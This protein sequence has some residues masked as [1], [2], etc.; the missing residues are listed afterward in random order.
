[1][2]FLCLLFF[3][4]SF[5][6]TNLF[7]YMKGRYVAVGF[8]EVHE[9]LFLYFFSSSELQWVS[10]R[11]TWCPQ[12]LWVDLVSNEVQPSQP[13][14]LSSESTVSSLKRYSHSSVLLGDMR[15]WEPCDE[16]SEFER[17]FFLLKVPNFNFCVSRTVGSCS[18]LTGRTGSVCWGDA[19]AAPVCA[20]GIDLLLVPSSVPKRP[21]DQAKTLLFSVWRR[22]Q[23][24]TTHH[25]L[26]LT[27]RAAEPFPGMPSLLRGGKW[28]RE[29]W[30]D[31]GEQ[32]LPCSS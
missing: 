4:F 19:Q 1:M 7:L 27:S 21:S 23:N 25:L 16:H 13:S 9:D 14:V 8:W 12:T 29:W 18:H 17:F 2:T 11:G 30:M 26:G 24:R 15:Y 31:G 5:H 6:F 32:K 28:L 20:V 3:E 10:L 22:W